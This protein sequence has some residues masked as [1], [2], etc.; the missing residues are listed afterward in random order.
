M[1]NPQK[2]NGFTPIANEI[3]DALCGIEI[4][5]ASRR[6]LDVIL[7]KTYGYQKKSDAISVTQFL[8]KTNLSERTIYRAIKKL[9]EMKLVITEK[10]IGRPT[11]YKLNKNHETWCSRPLTSRTGVLDDTPDTQDRG[12]PANYPPKPLTPRTD[13]IDSTKE[14][15]LATSK[16]AP[17]Q[18]KLLEGKDDKP[19]L[20]QE[21]DK[22]VKYFRDQYEKITGE[23]PVMTAWKKY[24]GMAQPFIKT[25]GLEEMKRAVDL[26]F[27]MDD[28]HFKKGG[29]HIMTFLN[30]I[31]IHKILNN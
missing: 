20:G 31:T 4:P 30:D 23:K 9:E 7:R 8:E 26:F 19:T 2:E 1:A 3:L 18:P 5:S 25:Y 24:N 6:C 17:S 21:A 11:E 28:Y 29:Y 27:D 12:T 14:K 13:T 10:K 22:L 15:I 16:L